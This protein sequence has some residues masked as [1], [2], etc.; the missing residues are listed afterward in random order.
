MSIHPTAIVHPD[1]VLGCNPQVGAYAV[2]EG[3]VHIG[4]DCR[5]DAHA[6][7]RSG[8]DIGSGVSVDS[9][10]VVGGMPQMRTPQA[11]AGRVSVGDRTVIREGVTIH[12]ATKAD[13]VTAIGNDCFLM[14]HCHVGHDSTVGNFVTLANNVMLAGHVQVGDSTFV[15]GG[16]GVHQF[17]R[18]GR[19]AMIGGNASISYDVPPY[20]IAADRNDICG[21]NVVGI[22]RQGVGAAAVADLKQCFRTVFNGRGNLRT[23]AQ[24]ALVAATCGTAPEGRSF[25]EFFSGGRRGFARARHDRVGDGEAEATAE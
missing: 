8:S 24:A 18:I 22:R 21:L 11:A 14:A 3:D 5:I 25:L 23:R 2:V 12:R 16:A 15:G 9:F 10:A 1:A 20:A 7:V 13:G 6:I 4:D 17:V 19:G